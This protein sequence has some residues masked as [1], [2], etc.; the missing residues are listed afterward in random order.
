MSKSCMDVV[1]TTISLQATT[2]A[3]YQ[4]K[5]PRWLRGITS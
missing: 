1:F 3:S 4:G 5:A 2:Q